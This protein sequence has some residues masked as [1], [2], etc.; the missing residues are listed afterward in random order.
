MCLN[1]GPMLR[2]SMYEGVNVWR[3]VVD[4]TVGEIA[5]TH[6]LFVQRVVLQ[7]VP[8]AGICMPGLFHHIF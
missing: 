2:G 8:A 6:G 5:N 4:V 3:F 7:S 1:E